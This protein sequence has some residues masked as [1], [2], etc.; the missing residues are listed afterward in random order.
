VGRV[1]QAM[2]E[3]RLA[4]AGKKSEGYLDPKTQALKNKRNQRVESQ[5]GE[6]LV[7]KHGNVLGWD[8]KNWNFKMRQTA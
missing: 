8:E 5:E 2:C 3:G 7:K 4:R 6:L 1:I